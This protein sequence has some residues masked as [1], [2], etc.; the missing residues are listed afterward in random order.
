MMLSVKSLTISAFAFIVLNIVVTMCVL[1][2][3][4]VNYPRILSLDT[5]KIK[6]YQIESMQGLT[7]A[8]SD[9]AI[10]KFASRLERVLTQVEQQGYLL[11]QKQSV[12]SGAEDISDAVID[13]LRVDD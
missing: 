6:A 3:K 11:L 9:Q 13:A 12:V 10:A 1:E 4:Q 2:Y 5:Q 8:E 7:R